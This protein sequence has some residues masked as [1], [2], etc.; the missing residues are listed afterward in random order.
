MKRRQFIKQ[1]TCGTIALAVGWK[2][3]FLLG[4]A[5][6][7]SHGGSGVV[8]LGMVVADV[9]MVDTTLV[10]HWVY[11]VNPVDANNPGHPGLPGPMVFAYE[12]EPIT[13]R[14]TNLIDDDRLRRFSIVG[15]NFLGNPFA[16]IVLSHDDAPGVQEIPPNF[17]F[18]TGQ[19]AKV[20]DPDVGIAFGDTFQVDIPANTLAP[21]TYI[22]KDPTLGNVSRVMG[23]HG[24][25]T[26]LPSRSN[27]IITN[28]YGPKAAVAVNNPNVAKLF[29]DFGKGLP[30]RDP[31]ALFPGEPWYATTDDNPRYRPRNLPPSSDMDWHHHHV[32]EHHPILEKYYYRT[33]IWVHGAIDPDQHAVIVPSLRDDAA[34]LTMIQNFRNQHEPRYFTINGRMGAYSAHSHDITM[35]STVGQPF[36]VRMVNCGLVTHSPHFHANHVFVVADNN[37]LGGFIHFSGPLESGQVFDNDNVAFV[38]TITLGPESRYDVIFPFTRPPDIPRILDGNGMLLPL[39]ELARE[40]LATVIGGVRQ[41]PLSYPMHCHTEMAQTAGG[42][43]YPQGQVIHIEFFGEFGRFYTPRA[44]GSI[45]PSLTPLLLSD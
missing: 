33:R 25:L 40:E 34:D 14:I 13:F 17:D 2:A 44:G 22:Y 6:A 39:A 15:N 27:G 1:A 5:M 9:E 24:V 38:D 28:P 30:L 29:D 3:P 43:N 11:T 35:A 41:D 45:V 10:P 37:A 23:L 19:S 7:M 36:L 31:N 16:N 20:S 18:G 4:D 42:G 32:F 12:D 8:H 21:G 26:I